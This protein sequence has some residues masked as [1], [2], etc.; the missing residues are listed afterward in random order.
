MKK[1]ILILFIKDTTKALDIVRRL[2]GVGTNTV[3]VEGDKHII[4]F[5]SSEELTVLKGKIMIEFDSP[6]L[7]FLID[8][9][10]QGSSYEMNFANLEPILLLDAT[11]ES[12]LPPIIK[13]EDL[14]LNDLL[15]LM[16]KNGFAALTDGQKAKLKKFSEE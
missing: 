15:D 7:F 8:A 10:L 14:T 6:P 9:S 2:F 11:V 5:R 4:S 13:D 3:T 12:L 1:Y 16:N